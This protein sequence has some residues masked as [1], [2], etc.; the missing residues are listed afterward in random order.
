MKFFKYLSFCLALSALAT[1]NQ[2]CSKDAPCNSIV[3]ENG[4]TCNDG[5][6]DCAEGYE[7]TN[8]STEVRAKFI[9]SYPGMDACS[10]TGASGTYTSTIATSTT[11][12]NSIL[13]TGLWEGFFITAINGTVSGNEITVP[14]Q[15]P[16]SDG[17]VI[18]G[19]GVMNADGTSIAWTF[20]VTETTNGSVDNCT[21]TATKQ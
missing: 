5:T 21:L 13:I 7:G 10:T 9:G 19:T 8:C 4:G 11:G 1:L 12:V 2:S 6:C 15:E 16:D 17:F 18:A 3:C 14:S 20:T